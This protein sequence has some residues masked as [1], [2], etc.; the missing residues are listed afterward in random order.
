MLELRKSL[1]GKSTDHFRVYEL[2]P[3]KG[4]GKTT[5]QFLHRKLIVTDSWVVT[6]SDNFSYGSTFHCDEFIMIFKDER[7]AEFSSGIYG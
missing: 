1:T 5:Y 2:N 3:K 7:M 6:G 4:L